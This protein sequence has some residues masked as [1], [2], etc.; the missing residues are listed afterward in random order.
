MFHVSY[1]IFYVARLCYASADISYFMLHI[2]YC[3]TW[4]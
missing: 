1:F 4:I 3:E 2:S